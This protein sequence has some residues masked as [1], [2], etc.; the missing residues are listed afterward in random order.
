MI[1]LRFSA[2]NRT[3]NLERKLAK[4]DTLLAKRIQEK[5]RYYLDK[6]VRE[7][8]ETAPYKTG[9]LRRSLLAR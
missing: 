1:T 5:G 7:A 4:V 2:S 3:R 6:I 9:K 8:K